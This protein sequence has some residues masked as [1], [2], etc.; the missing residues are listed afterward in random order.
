[1]NVSI[2]IDYN[3]YS[4]LE[5]ISLRL[6]DEPLP[7]LF[8]LHAKLSWYVTIL[9]LIQLNNISKAPPTGRAPDGFLTGYYTPQIPFVLVLF[10]IPP[11]F[12]H[13]LGG[14][15]HK[16]LRWESK[17]VFSKVE[18]AGGDDEEEEDDE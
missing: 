2:F 8:G 1:M 4:N 12:A 14:I 15:I 5:W 18:A 17:T 13:L 6:V 16:D 11:L 9:L 10:T 3:V 7:L